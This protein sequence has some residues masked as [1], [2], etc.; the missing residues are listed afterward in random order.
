MGPKARAPKCEALSPNVEGQCKA[1]PRQTL[2][3]IFVAKGT[4][5]LLSALVF[6]F[7]AL[8]CAFLMNLTDRWEL[9]VTAYGIATAATIASLLFISY[10][11]TSPEG[12]DGTSPH[13]YHRTA[14]SR[15]NR[16][17]QASFKSRQRD[18]ARPPPLWVP[19]WT[20]TG[21]FLS[22]LNHDEDWLVLP[23][24]KTRQLYV[25]CYPIPTPVH[26]SPPASS[27]LTTFGKGMAWPSPPLTP[28]ELLRS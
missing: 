28:T 21:P 12:V 15:R 25:G 1:P 10:A 2:C 3:G 8:F 22:N 6:S 26:T 14:S 19:D 7:G 5:V 23:Q 16:T 18:V 9:Q 27:F 24:D 20:D 17:F 13:D 4:C 11:R